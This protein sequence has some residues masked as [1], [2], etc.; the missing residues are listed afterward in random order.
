MTTTTLPRC[1]TRAEVIAEMEAEARRPRPQV[2]PSLP[3]DDRPDPP[4]WQ[5]DEYCERHGIGGA[6]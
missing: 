4:Q 5:I 2:D 3:R 6:R 1:R